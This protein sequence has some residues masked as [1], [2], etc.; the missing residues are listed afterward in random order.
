MGGIHSPA[1]NFLLLLCAIIIILLPV[2]AQGQQSP[3]PWIDEMEKAKGLT[4]GDL[5]PRFGDLPPA[6]DMD[7][8]TGTGRDDETTTGTEQADNISGAERTGPVNPDTLDPRNPK[9][10][11]YIRDLKGMKL[12]A[13][14]AAVTAAGFKYDDPVPGTPA[15]TA[16]AE[17]TIQRQEPGPDQYLKK[18]QVLK[19]VFHTA[20]VPE[21][22][23]LPDFIGESLRE[24]KKWLDN[25]KLKMQRPKAGS[26]APTK[27]KSGTIEAQEPVAGT[28]MKSG[29]KVT[30]TVYSKYVDTRRV[31][32]VVEFSAGKAKE[33]IGNAGLKADPK[34]SAKKPSSREQAKTV[35]RQSP[36]AGTS[37]PPGTKVTIYVYGPFVDTVTVP[38]VRKLSY[39]E[40]M[41][42]LETAGLSM[43]KQDAGRPGNRSL[44]NTAQKQ[45][46]VSGTEVSKGQTV[47]VW[48]YGRYTPTREEQV[49]S[50]DCLRF[51]G[52]RAYWDDNTGQ[53]KCG[54]F[55]G[56]RWNLN[57]SACVSQHDFARQWCKKNRPGSISFRKPNG[58]YEC[59]CPDGYAWTT[60]KTHCEKLVPPNELCARNYPGSVA[61]GRTSDGKV[62]CE[63]PQGYTWAVG[64]KHCEKLIPPNELCA[65]KYPGSVPTG[66]NAN[67]QVNCDCPQGFKWVSNPKRCV[68]QHAGRPSCSCKVDTSLMIRLDGFC[69]TF[70]E[71]RDQQNRLDP[72]GTIRI[73]HIVHDDQF[74]RGWRVPK[75]WLK[76]RYNTCG[77]L[78]KDSEDGCAR[79]CR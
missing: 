30:F 78:L 37:V 32:K 6:P 76:G 5:E 50:T 2:L 71:S 9:V 58:G 28:V 49:A 43:S 57:N 74:T 69:T 3:D 62:N 60:D 75:G 33:L 26:P 55:D 34:P 12:S 22:L 39:E 64:N 53:P 4:V 15:K 23:T 47:S 65:R 48:F 35:A 66:R 79:Y 25:N 19:L 56:L 46:P 70:A 40:A 77:V 31:P 13:A 42:Q 61:R 67:G 24:A 29:G 14:K 36:A 52:S 11:N 1:R 27:V 63:C 17:G 68:R 41:R 16:E 21:K 59:R 44:A 18:E 45:E 10:A 51:P 20:Y 72:H 7:D 54:C 38:D 8:S 73:V